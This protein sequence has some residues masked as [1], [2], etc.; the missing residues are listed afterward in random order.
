VDTLKHGAIDYLQKDRNLEMN[1]LSVIQRIEVVKKMLKER[2][3]SIM[4]SFLSLI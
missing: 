4:K 3:P 2:K 1:I